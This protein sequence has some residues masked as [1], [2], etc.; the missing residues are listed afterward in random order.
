MGKGRC[1]VC[2]KEREKMKETWGREGA[3]YALCVC[4][5]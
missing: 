1:I 4:T 2:K 5:L 3:R